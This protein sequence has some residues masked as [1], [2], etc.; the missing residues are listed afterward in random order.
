[1]ICQS[2]HTSSPFQHTASRG[3]AIDP[4]VC[5]CGTFHPSCSFQMVAVMSVG[6]HC[7]LTYTHKITSQSV[8]AQQHDTATQHTTLHHTTLGHI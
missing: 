3:K 5:L 8:P 6:C 1:M 7:Q 2:K 4:E